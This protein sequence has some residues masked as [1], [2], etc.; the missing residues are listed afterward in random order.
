MA[1]SSLWTL[2]RNGSAAVA[3]CDLDIEA[4]SLRLSSL[5]VD[6]LKFSVPVV[7]GVA[8]PFAFGD[9]VT[10]FNDTTPVFAGQ[11]ATD[12]ELALSG[13]KELLNFT[14]SGPWLALENTVFQQQWTVRSAGK[15]AGV[16]NT[17]TEP[18]SRVILGQK[19]DGTRV[20]S[21][22]QILEILTWATGAGAA[23]QFA[24]ETILTGV[25]VP[26]RES[27]DISCA[28]AVRNMLRY[29]PDAVGWFDYATAPPTLHISA[30][31]DLASVT[32]PMVSDIA[33]SLQIKPRRDIQVSS[34]TLK[35]EQ[36][37]QD[38]DESWLET[39]L[40]KY[41]PGC[42]EQAVKALVQTISMSG[43]KTTRQKQVVVTQS[44]PALDASD[45]AVIEWWKKRNYAQNNVLKKIPVNKLSVV[46]GSFYGVVNPD[47]FMADGV[48]A[49]T[50]TFEDIG[51]RE[52]VHGSVTDWMEKEWSNL[53]AANASMNVILS[54][55][56]P[57]EGL[58][59]E[60]V[61]EVQA[62]FNM[63]SRN[64]AT[65]NKLWLYYYPV[66]TNATTMTYSRVT[67][68]VAGEPIPTGLAQS[69][70]TS[71]NT[72][73]YEGSFETVDQEISLA[74]GVGNSFNLSGG[75]VDYATMNAVVQEIS[76]ELATG[77]TTV[78][79]GPPERL[80]PQNIVEYLRGLRQS[81]PSFSIESRTSGKDSGAST[82]NG[83]GH[84][85]NGSGNHGGGIAADPIDFQLTDAST[86]SATQLGIYSGRIY[87][88][89][90]GNMWTVRRL[91]DG[92]ITPVAVSSETMAWLV[93]TY[94][95]SQQP[96]VIDSVAFD[97][98][99][100]FPALT[101]GVL[102][103]GLGYFNVTGGKV[104][105]NSS[106][107]GSQC[108][109]VWRNWFSNPVTYSAECNPA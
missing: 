102:C 105:V 88:V 75:E 77:K 78:K 25:D 38:D 108:F 79:F 22:A 96:P 86:A 87:E 54:Y 4:L 31:S 43:P 55:Q 9:A 5:A 36:T 42:N 30:R 47:Q 49:Q 53:N 109:E 39:T 19:I 69:L 52:L 70:C 51:K 32:L 93:I 89:A 81:V 46:P 8:A 83:S 57:V 59:D 20:Q 85:P 91:T 26:L 15:T 23:F 14:V 33:E 17:T 18:R 29:T 50:A 24:T 10:L 94:D 7:A 44:L 6:T 12:P 66:V 104:K 41:P 106:P 11:I 48:T 103:V 28:E 58:T 34:V 68:S 84:V 74:V 62:L 67:N 16:P 100:S 40:D 80:T 72:L 27:L 76:H 3:A 61:A 101:P 63:G 99:S 45:T 95:T 2:A 56:L 64:P 21:G 92:Q 73:H 13:S 71:L 90:T 35:Y 97:M 98:G 1:L 37:V 82:V 60:E 107:L 65:S